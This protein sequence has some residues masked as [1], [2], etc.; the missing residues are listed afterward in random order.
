MLVTIRTWEVPDTSVQE[1]VRLSPLLI[2]ICQTHKE[3]PSSITQ[4]NIETECSLSEIL[5]IEI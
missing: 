3:N 4:L 2:H 5:V 1:W